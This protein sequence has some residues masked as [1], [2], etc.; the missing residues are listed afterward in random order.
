MAS[1]APRASSNHAPSSSAFIGTASGAY[2]PLRIGADTGCDVVLRQGGP[3]EALIWPHGVRY[4]QRVVSGHGRVCGEAATW[5]VLDHGDILEI[6]D[7]T[8][9]F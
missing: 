7:A 2:L 3:L 9:G 1:I 6:D 5:V 4:I 8:F